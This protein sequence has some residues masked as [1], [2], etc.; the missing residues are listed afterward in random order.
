MPNVL[1]GTSNPHRSRI[2]WNDGALG[3]CID[4]NKNI[5]SSIH[6]HRWARSFTSSNIPAIEDDPKRERLCVMG[7]GR[8]RHSA[9]HIGIKKK[10]STGMPCQ[11][12]I[13]VSISELAEQEDWYLMEPSAV[14][15]LDLLILR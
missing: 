15:G 4:G 2:S 12:G 10:G 13:G 5:T 6:Q 11:C 9:Y 3:G 7:F 8:L 1:F 14:G